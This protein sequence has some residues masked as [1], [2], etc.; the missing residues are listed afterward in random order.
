ML[1]S[2]A[3]ANAALKACVKIGMGSGLSIPGKLFARFLFWFRHRYEFGENARR[4]R[5]DC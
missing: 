3:A 5:F 2:L 4:R 1:S